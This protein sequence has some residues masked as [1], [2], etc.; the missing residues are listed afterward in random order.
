MIVVAAGGRKVVVCG[1]IQRERLG[2]GDSLWWNC[3]W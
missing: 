3:W 1:N 2:V